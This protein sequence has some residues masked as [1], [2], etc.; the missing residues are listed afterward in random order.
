[1]DEG[2]L[3]RLRALYPE[4][5]F[6]AAAQGDGL[7]G[8]QER[9]A[10]FFDRALRPVQLLFPHSAAG[11]MHRLRGIASDIREEHTEEG[12]LFS[13]RLP[14]A[15]AGRYA[16]FAVNGGVKSAGALEDGLATASTSASE[17]DA[18]ADPEATDVR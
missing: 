13:G 17:L 7:E 1:V 4:A 14:V 18:A 15:E 6:V 12:V 5:E 16:R 2:R 3:L 8:L 9:L 11:E 10:A